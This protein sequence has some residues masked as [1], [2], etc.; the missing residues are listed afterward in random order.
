MKPI[1][2]YSVLETMVWLY[3]AVLCSKK[4]NPEK[5]DIITDIF[6]Y[7]LISITVRISCMI[8]IYLRKEAEG[9]TKITKLNG[10][11]SLIHFETDSSYT[12]CRITHFISIEK[13]DYVMIQS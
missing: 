8:G 12:S 6:C 10:Y 3:A 1:S 4:F 2:E 11:S 9:V 5:Q 7:I 13:T